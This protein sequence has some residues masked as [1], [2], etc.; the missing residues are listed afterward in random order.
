MTVLNFLI[1]LPVMLLCLIVQVAVSF[2]CVRYYVHHEPQV[3]GGFLA[4]IRPLLVASLGMMFGT[5][6]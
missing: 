4:G 5:L 3:G 6:V 2:W 1:G